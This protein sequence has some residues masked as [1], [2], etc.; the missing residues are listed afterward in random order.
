M[1]VLRNYSCLY[2][3]I[4]PDRDGEGLCG[5]LGIEPMPVMC[6]GSA[7]ILSPQHR[8]CFLEV[9]VWTSSLVLRIRTHEEEVRG[10]GIMGEGKVEW[11]EGG[12]GAGHLGSSLNVLGQI[13]W[14]QG[15][16]L[17]AFIGPVCPVRENTE[18]QENI[19]KE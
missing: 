12:R 5:M 9:L 4:T 18:L 16:L 17:M 15:L 13:S 1:G 8:S 2:S 6:K 3:E 10:G 11:R 7:L 19:N 14:S